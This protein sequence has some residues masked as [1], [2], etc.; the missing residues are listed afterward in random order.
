[1]TLDLG[2]LTSALADRYRIE[3]EVGRGGMATVYLA[4]DRKHGRRVAIKVLRPTVAAAI[5]PER[6]LREIDIAAQ[7]AHPHILPLYDSGYADGFC[8]Y[9]MPFVD[10]ETLRDL[11]N[12]EKQVPVEDVL[13]VVHQVAGALA[14]AH[15]Q[16]YVHRDIK[17]ENV[18]I[19]EG[20]ALVAD[21]GIGKAVCDVCEDDHVTV[22]GTPIGTPAYMSPEQSMGEE[23][24]A[25][26][27]IYSL[28]CVVYEMLTGEPPFQA[29]SAQA[30]LMKHVVDAVPSAR[31]LNPAVPA[32]LDQALRRALSKEREDRYPS[33]TEFAE[34]L[35]TL[36]P[37]AVGVTRP[38]EASPARQEPQ[39][40]WRLLAVGAVVGV[41]AVLSGWWLLSGPA[42]G[43]HI[44]SL[45]VLPLANV[46]GDAGQRAF[47]DGLHDALIAE[48]AQI[49]GLTV[50]SRT[51]V[52]RYRD[53]ELPASEIADELGVDALLEGSVLRHGDS[54]RIT[55]QLIGLAPERHL[56]SGRYDRDVGDVLAVHA[57]VARAIGNEVRSEVAPERETAP[58]RARQVDPAV[59]DAYLEGRFQASRGTVEGFRLAMRSFEE[60]ITMDPEFAP[61]YSAIALS[62]H[63][64]G[65]YGGLPRRVA[66]PR[67]KVMA[68]RALTLDDGQAEARAVLAGI[69]AMWEWDFEGAGRDYELAVA[70]DP[71]SPVARRWH[72]YYLTSM[73][74]HDE[75]VAE[76]LRGVDLDPFNPTARVVLADQLVYARR[77]REAIVELERVLE[78]DPTRLRASLLLEDAYALTG[79]HELAVSV[80]AAQL[81]TS[82]ADKAEL[83]G[84]WTAAGAAGYWRWRLAE[85]ERAVGRRYVPPSEFARA[86]A[87][88]GR[89]D[90]A[91]EW[92][93]RAYRERD[94]M[95]LL[96]VSPYYD[97][98]RSDPRFQRL[99]KR[100]GLPG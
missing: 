80:R 91:L 66:E 92:L 32:Y 40:P 22:A 79:N 21:F 1:M 18:L 19:S 52:L 15:R 83:E 4:E 55:A 37:A 53:T 39:R 31:D 72:A 14:H 70:L 62:I 46:S 99:V 24:D 65:F 67:A 41:L 51:S 64:L 97:A 43:T 84:A 94:Q 77:F 76:A 88:L 60:A 47:V 27:D 58:A 57:E 89:R 93:E 63:L 23:V 12:R 73:G 82:G 49:P 9:V 42:R 68:Q 87:A 5:G 59:V 69:R 95:E 85:L 16:H 56:W 20:H 38:V 96:Q 81:V 6:F 29:P 48:V 7:L 90:L 34:A 98:L 61:A 100:V 86:Y 13:R 26:S 45:A 25:R 33:V 71:S 54:V 8:Y 28:A 35:G 11:M 30:V 17:P 75:A 3:R 78:Q 74:R 50:I 36:S 44:G 2:R 10:G